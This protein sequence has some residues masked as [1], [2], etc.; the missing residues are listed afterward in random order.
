MNI[1]FTA[2]THFGF[3]KIKIPKERPW[4]SAEEMDSDLIHN[5][6]S[7]VGKNDIIYHLG[8]FSKIQSYD[9][10]KSYIQQLNGKIILIAGN[11]D[12]NHDTKTK[13]LFHDYY[14]HQYEH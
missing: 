9:T 8:D 10:V 6:N 2:D 1:F 5:W 13:L 14:K 12:W 4:N 3:D 11:H 7:V